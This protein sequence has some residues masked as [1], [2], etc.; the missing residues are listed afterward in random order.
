MEHLGIYSNW[1]TAQRILSEFDELTPILLAE[2]EAELKELRAYAVGHNPFTDFRDR[3]KPAQPP[4]YPNIA[5]LLYSVVDL[6]NAINSAFGAISE[7]PDLGA[8]E[9]Y[10]S[11]LY[12]RVR[13]QHHNQ[14]TVAPAMGQRFNTSM[15]S[16]AGC[17]YCGWMNEAERL[18]REILILYKRHRFSDVRGEYA[19]PLYHWFLRI[20]FDYW[21]WSFD[22]WGRDFYTQVPEPAQTSNDQISGRQSCHS[23]KDI[24]TSSEYFDEPVLD[25]IF[26]H[27]RDDSLAHM[28]DHLIWL[29][30]YY[31]HRTRSIDGTE[32][33]NDL[34]HT[35]FPAIIL[36]WF[37]LREMLDLKN[38]TIIHP[39]MQSGCAQLP[40]PKPF[41]SD[42]LLDLILARLRLEEIPSLGEMPIDA[43]PPV[44]KDNWLARIFRS[45]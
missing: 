23:I 7:S 45:K 8:L 10:Y 29:C 40:L 24:H 19:Q 4:L 36:A 17:L 9:K 11:Y 28:Q 3:S 26:D 39:L 41:Y 15:A 27:W 6:S 32:F 30:D 13:L 21:G 5:R 20:C 16:L 18:A 38:P 43:P 34:L 25:E 44:P 12:W 1:I 14:L 22:E 42:D 31:T 33:G 37:R 35:R 2:R